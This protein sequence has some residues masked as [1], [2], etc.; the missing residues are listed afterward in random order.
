MDE[1]DLTKGMNP[2][3]LQI[4]EEMKDLSKETQGIPQFAQDMMVNSG[5]FTK[6]QVDFADRYGRE[7]GS[8]A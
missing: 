4:F 1:A 3:K 7:Q 6:E 5:F 2:E 8:D